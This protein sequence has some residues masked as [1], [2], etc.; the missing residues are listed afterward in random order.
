M[1]ATE[2]QRMQVATATDGLSTPVQI[3]WGQ[4][5]PVATAKNATIL[6]D[7]L[8]HGKLNIFANARH[9]T[10]E[11]NSADFLNVTLDWVNGGYQLP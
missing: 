7:R 5:D 10:W 6:H 11:E 1:K 9:Y 3:I 4:N 8:P 2:I